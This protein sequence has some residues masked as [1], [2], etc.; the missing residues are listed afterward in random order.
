VLTHEGSQQT[1]VTS[2]RENPK[3]NADPGNAE[4]IG[5]IKTYFHPYSKIL[6]QENNQTGYDIGP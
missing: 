6:L 2:K 5:C 4:F 1:K 3:L